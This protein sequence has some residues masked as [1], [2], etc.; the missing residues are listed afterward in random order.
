MLALTATVTD[1]MRKDAITSLDMEGCEIV[2]LSPNRP[3][4][5]YE[6]KH[7]SDIEMDMAHLVSSI[8]THSITA[9]RVIVYCR[10]IDLCADLYAHFLHSLGESSYFPLGSDQV[11]DNRLFGMYHSN[12]PFYNK[13]VILQSLSVQDGIVRVVFATNALGMGVNMAG[14]NT[15]IRYGAPSSIDDYFQESGR[16]GRSGDQAS[17]VVYWK[18][19]QC[20]LRK[21]P[22]T[23]HEIEVN[24]VRQYLENCTSCRRRELLRYFDLNLAVPDINPLLCCDVCRCS[25]QL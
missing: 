6:V 13:Q 22:E 2:S 11:S 21:E 17:S 10:T 7:Q 15:I 18:P 8:Q 1:L 3:N 20:P 25:A 24:A 9:E 19:V 16:A 14:V 12:T 4:I 5:F 23:I